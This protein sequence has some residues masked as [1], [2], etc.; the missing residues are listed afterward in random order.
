M[1]RHARGHFLVALADFLLVFVGVI[2]F[3]EAGL[4][5]ENPARPGD[6]HTWCSAELD[7]P[8]QVGARQTYLKAGCIHF[9]AGRVQ[10]LDQKAQSKALNT[11]LFILSKGAARI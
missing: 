5:A 7:R 11:Y 8:I 6:I 1:G 2:L 10:R 9:K 3:D 4:S